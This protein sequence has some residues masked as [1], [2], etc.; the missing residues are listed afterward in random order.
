MVTPS[1]DNNHQ[2]LNNQG[3]LVILSWPTFNGFK[4]SEKQTV[5]SKESVGITTGGPQNTE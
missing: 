5:S 4:C 1:E 2:D 3:R